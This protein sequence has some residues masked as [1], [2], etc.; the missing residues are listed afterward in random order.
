MTTMTLQEITENIKE[1]QEETGST[2]IF[3][4][5]DNTSP[6]GKNMM[7]ACVG[8][9]IDLSSLIAAAMSED[10]DIERIVKMALAGFVLHNATKH[11]CGSTN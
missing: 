7:S 9:G 1:W 5:K 4:A 8:K 6:D 3:L 2:F 10:T 11:L